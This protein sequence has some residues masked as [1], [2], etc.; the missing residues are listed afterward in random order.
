MELSIVVPVYRSA[1]C[2]AELAHRVRE[3]VSRRFQSYE[4][5]LVN[6]GSP[7]ASW[8]VIGRLT[9]EH[10][11]VVGVNLRRNVGQDN[12]IMAGLGVASGDVIVIMDDD[13]QHDPVDIPALYEQIEK[14]HD[15]AYAR[16]EHK[17]QAL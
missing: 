7:D 2:L 9:R 11:F 5:I 12:A 3:A 14:G 16:F 13:L 17:K 4:L 15:V 6:D 1:A 10:P 8:D